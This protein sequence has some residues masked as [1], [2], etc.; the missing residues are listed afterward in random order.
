MGKGKKLLV[1]I[2]GMNKKSSRSCRNILEKN[3]HPHLFSVSNKSIYSDTEKM[4]MDIF[5]S[6]FLTILRI[7]CSCHLSST[8]N[9]FLF[10]LAVFRP[11]FLF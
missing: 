10:P 4:G 7:F 11:P 6:M 1:R 8:S 5:S 9:F 3:I 2:G